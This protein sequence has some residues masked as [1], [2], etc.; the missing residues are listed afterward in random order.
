MNFNILFILPWKYILLKHK[1]RFDYLVKVS[2][3]I[4]FKLDLWS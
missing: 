3:Q 4:R 2:L 1:V